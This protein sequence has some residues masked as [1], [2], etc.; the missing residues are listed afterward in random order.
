RD[1]LRYVGGSSPDDDAVI[2]FTA[3]DLNTCGP[4]PDCS[5]TSDPEGLLGLIYNSVDTP[6][7]LAVRF[8]GCSSPILP[9]YPSDATPLHFRLSVERREI[10]AHL[11]P[12][13]ACARTIVSSS[14]GEKPRC[15]TSGDSWLHHRR[16]QDLPE[17][18]GIDLLIKDQFLGPCFCTR[19]CNS[20][21]SSGL[22]GPLIRSMFF[23]TELD[24]VGSFVVF[25][26]LVVISFFV[27]LG[28]KV[29]R[30]D[31]SKQERVFIREGSGEGNCNRYFRKRP[32]LK[33]GK[34]ICLNSVCVRLISSFESRES[35]R[36]NGW[37]LGIQLYIN[38]C[39]IR[40]HDTRPTDAGM[41]MVS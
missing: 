20:S 18:P 9:S 25:C 28:Q 38:T 13:R 17:R 35:C 14:S 29:L 23:R 24:I 40:N 39:Q 32:R 31:K 10:V 7:P 8:N 33:R 36:K 11:L 41:S 4:P 2:S 34:C 27:L 30:E 21:S 37:E 22:H 16:R 3:P 19:L 12:N 1:K 6:P 5:L 26:F 15:S